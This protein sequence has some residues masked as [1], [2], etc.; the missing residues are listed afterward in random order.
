MVEITPTITTP[1]EF[2]KDENGRAFVAIYCELTQTTINEYT[3][4]D[5]DLSS[6]DQLAGIRRGEYELELLKAIDEMASATMPSLPTALGTARQY[7]A[8]IFNS[9]PP[10][11]PPGLSNRSLLQ[12]RQHYTE[13]QGVAATGGVLKHHEM[14][15]P[16]NED[17]EAVVKNMRSN[18]FNMQSYIVGLAVDSFSEAAATFKSW[19]GLLIFEV[20]ELEE[21]FVNGQLAYVRR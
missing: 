18:V 16:D 3:W 2:F 1:I 7:Y 4:G 9:K 20:H 6:L 8:Y 19:K 11:T 5:V 10:T 14:T 13:L 15:F 17:K 21:A 12:K